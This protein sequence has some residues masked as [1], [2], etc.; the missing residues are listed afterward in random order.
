MVDSRTVHT[1]DV[2]EIKELRIKKVTSVLTNPNSAMETSANET[3]LENRMTRERPVTNHNTQAND[4]GS[5][6]EY[7]VKG[8]GTSGSSNLMRI[9]ER[10]KTLG[11]RQHNEKR[12]S[13][14]HRDQPLEI[15]DAMAKTMPSG[16]FFKP[17]TV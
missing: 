4:Y 15:K 10:R 2:G 11:T 13:S 3:R 8:E 1:V 16:G 6:V 12:S 17:N 14:V 9:R 5:S 7:S